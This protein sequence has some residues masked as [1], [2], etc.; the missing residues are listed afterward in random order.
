MNIRKAPLGVGVVAL[1]A[2]IFWL[3]VIGA[4]ILMFLLGGFGGGGWG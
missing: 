4:W 2:T 3:V 1:A